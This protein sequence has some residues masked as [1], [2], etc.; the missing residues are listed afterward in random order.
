MQVVVNEVQGE[1][2]TIAIEGPMEG[3]PRV[4][5]IIAKEDSCDID[6]VDESG[7][8]VTNGIIADGDFNRLLITLK[9]GANK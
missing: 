4:V 8:P 3:W 6:F 5:V 1:V 2:R 9:K 7:K